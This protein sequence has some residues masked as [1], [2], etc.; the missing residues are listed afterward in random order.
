MRVRRYKGRKYLHVADSGMPNYRVPDR[1]ISRANFPTICKA[2]LL[3]F[4]YA[5]GATETGGKEERLY[6]LEICRSAAGE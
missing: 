3:I 4:H 2:A 6:T 5:D 1:F